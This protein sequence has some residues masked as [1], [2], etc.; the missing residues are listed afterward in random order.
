MAAAQSVFFSSPA[1][2]IW[3]SDYD[4]VT[5]SGQFVL[6]RKT[7]SL[8]AVPTGEALL[9]VSADTR[10]RLFLNG[11][12]ISFGPCKGYPSHWNY[13]TV[14]IQPHLQAG[15]NVLAAR[16]LRFS[17]VHD[18]C[19]SMTRT[20]FAGL[21]VH[22]QFSTKSEEVSLH[23]DE[24]WK[25]KKDNATQLVGPSSWDYRLG[26]PFLNLNEQVDARRGTRNWHTNEYND[27]AWQHAVPGL[28]HRKMSPMLD[29]R[30]LFPRTIPTLTENDARFDG[31]V[32]CDGAIPQDDWQAMIGGEAVVTIPANT[33]TWVEVES[34]ILTTGFLDLACEHQGTDEQACSFEILYSE[35]YESPMENFMSRNKGDRTD[36]RNG[37]LYGM[38]DYYTV[39]GGEN[40]YTPFW[41][42]TFRYVRLTVS[43]KD[44]PI[45]IR[46][47][48]YRSTHYPLNI[49]STIQ[50]SSALTRKLWDISINTLKNCM[51]ETYEDCPFYEQNQFAMDSRSQI[52]F[53]YFLSRDDRLARKAMQD[54]Y[55]SRRE[56]GLVETHFPNPG[57]T[58]NIPTF[59][60][61]WVLMV[62]DHMVYFGDEKLVEYYAGGVDGVLNYFDARI[63][64]LGLVGKFEPD[65]W[66]FVDWVDDWHTPG[67][68]FRGMAVPKCYYSKGSATYHS[69]V[70]AYVLLHAAEC[71]VFIGR[72][73]TAL[74]YRRRHQSVLQAIRQHCFDPATGLFL[75]GPGS[76]GEL[77]Q[78][79]QIFAVL[80]GLVEGQ[81]AAQL[82]RRAILEREHLG[83]AKAS[84][85]MGFYLFRAASKAGVYEDCWDTL[86]QPWKKMIA[87]NLT[88]W[89]ESES[90]MRSDCHGWSATPLWEIGTEILGVQHK[91][92]TYVD[93]MLLMDGGK[94]HEEGMKNVQIMPRPSL[95]DDIVADILVGDGDNEVVHIVKHF[96]NKDI[97]IRLPSYL[98]S[99]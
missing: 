75:D 5:L 43:T 98:N 81:E 37:R 6:F 83:L 23:S 34:S 26:P 94:R 70:Y 85:A 14:D 4:D 68:G 16:V 62:H 91:S 73:D 57:R 90:T 27:D 36:F 66:A 47:F 61:F 44:A 48:S 35:C 20:P 10:Y 1:K 2:W 18:G 72:R 77:S 40:H 56:D 41:F 33:R 92:Q 87:D 19:L 39:H 28:P 38:T 45:V 79:T 93:K 13:E 59:S 96:G 55:A 3:L 64:E 50:T 51:H 99:V 46:S 95:L 76:T 69:L 30:R 71:M 11:Q 52:L 97:E 84:F 25:L 7:F 82:I 32:T 17:F 88:T 65:C 58:I 89:A 8:T 9:H 24:S 78:H 53:T 49:R 80:A 86:I 31:V 63:N 54:F 22:C 15:R 67:I 60:L 21:L 74:A 29:P 12:R 42:R